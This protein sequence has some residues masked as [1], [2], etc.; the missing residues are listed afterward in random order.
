MG[1]LDTIM[2]NPQFQSLI[3]RMQQPQQGGFGNIMKGFQQQVPLTPLSQNLAGGF[4]QPQNAGRSP[5]SS[6]LSQ[7]GG[8]PLMNP[9]NFMSQYGNVQRPT[10]P[11]PPTTPGLETYMENMPRVISSPQPTPQRQFSSPVDPT[12]STWNRIMAGRTGQSNDPAM[13]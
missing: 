11:T 8:Y 5:V 4:G 2:Q 13:G 7:M 10:T 3:Q 9:A 6:L 12:A 1:W